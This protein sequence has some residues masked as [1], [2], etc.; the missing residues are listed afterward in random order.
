[1]Y[2]GSTGKANFDKES[3]VGAKGSMVPLDIMEQR[4][5]DL[6]GKV[7]KHSCCILGRVCIADHEAVGVLYEFAGDGDVDS[8]LL[9]VSCDHPDLQARHPLVLALLVQDSLTI[10]D[11]H[12]SECHCEWRIDLRQGHLKAQ[13]CGHIH[14]LQ[15]FLRMAR[16]GG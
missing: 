13:A 3:C 12:L 11:T 9:L 2:Q 1:M 8:S 5:R 6:V 7:I 10:P 14:V 4:R 16:A 15:R